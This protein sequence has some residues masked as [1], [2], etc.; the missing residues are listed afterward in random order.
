MPLNLFIIGPSGCGKSTQAKLIA[1]KYHLAHFSTGKLFREQMSQKTF[2]G[3]KA[4]KFIDKGVFCPDELVL[5]I[6]FS[7]L[8]SVNYMNFIVDGTPRSPTQSKSVEDHLK[9]HRQTSTTLIHLSVTYQE[10]Q[11]RRAKMGQ[12]FQDDSRTDNSPA[13]IDKRQQEYEKGIK[14]ILKFYKKRNQ[15][16]EV[17]GNRPIEPIFRDICQKIDQLSINKNQ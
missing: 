15:L 9:T 4:K 16:I 8:D 14:P 10:I 13:D 5:K 6:L 17:D 7:A 1:D 12:S 11:K 2:L 3:L